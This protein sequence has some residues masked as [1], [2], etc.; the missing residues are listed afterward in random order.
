M[1][2][3]FYSQG[4]NFKE[5]IGMLK[6][7]L[8]KY[9][10]SLGSV[11][12]YFYVVEG[13]AENA[14][15][16]ILLI[17]PPFTGKCHFEQKEDKLLKYILAK[18]NI[19]KT[20]ITYAHLVPLKKHTKAD[21]KAFGYWMD[22]IVEIVSPKLIVVLGE[23]AELVFFKRKFIMKDYHGKIIGDTNGIPIM[24]TYSLDY[25]IS[26]S[27]YEDQSYKDFLEANDWSAIKNE[28]DRRIA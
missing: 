20:F 17:Q 11:R 10:K 5:Q 23:D 18:Y 13:K 16:N 3:L 27:S 7:D 24:L 22:K 26:K 6:A 2:D 15:N 21:I 1:P 8:V 28:Y 9:A 4:S 25:Y 14:G 19:F 12:K